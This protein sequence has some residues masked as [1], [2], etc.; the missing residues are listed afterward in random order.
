MKSCIRLVA[1]EDAMGMWDAKVVMPTDFVYVWTFDI[2]YHE[3]LKEWHYWGE[4]SYLR[5]LP[6]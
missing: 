6:R 1:R 2:E 4:Y 3:F 5:E